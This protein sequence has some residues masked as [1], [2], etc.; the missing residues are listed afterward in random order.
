[1]E[2]QLILSIHEFRRITSTAA[3]TLGS[4]GKES[5]K[6]G[7]E[8]RKRERETHSVEFLKMFN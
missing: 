4:Q 3:G 5:M 1:M 8:I 7:K 2:F 6:A